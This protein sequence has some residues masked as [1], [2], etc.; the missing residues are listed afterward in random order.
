[1]YWAPNAVHTPMHAK[2]EHLDKFKDHKRQKL[3]AMTW[4]LD[5]NIGKIIDKLKEKGVYENTL[6][7]FLSDNGGADK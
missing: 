1:M 5:E 4:S 2:E 3:A 6:I 7:F